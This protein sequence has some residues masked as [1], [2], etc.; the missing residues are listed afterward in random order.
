M[1]RI[2]ALA[3]FAAVLSV[4]GCCDQ[5]TVEVDPRKDIDLCPAMCAHLDKL[6]CEEGQDLP[7]GT[8]CAQMCRDMKEGDIPI[9]VRCYATR[10]SCDRAHLDECTEP[11]PAPPAE[12]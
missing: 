2:I 10:S 8:P 5:P 4:A 1:N 12:P 3:A 7:D 6:G 11:E 9:D